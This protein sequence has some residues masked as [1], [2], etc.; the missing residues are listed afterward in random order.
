MHFF[1]SDFAGSFKAVSDLEWMDTLVEQLLGLLKDG[2]SQHDNT[3][4][5]ISNFIVLG[6]RKFSQ[7]FGGLVMDFHFF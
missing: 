1:Y 6:S 7:K 4:G 3:G 5:S 2:T